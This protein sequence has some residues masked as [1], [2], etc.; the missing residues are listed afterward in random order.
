MGWESGLGSITPFS[1]SFFGLEVRGWDDRW[2]IAPSN[3]ALG[4]C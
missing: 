1:L 3:M 2:D 4:K